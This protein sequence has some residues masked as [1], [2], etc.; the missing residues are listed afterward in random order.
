MHTNKNLCRS[1]QTKKLTAESSTNLSSDIFNV[2]TLAEYIN[3]ERHLKGIELL[4]KLN[5]RTKLFFYM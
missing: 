4:F 2:A 5:S 3:S 1:T